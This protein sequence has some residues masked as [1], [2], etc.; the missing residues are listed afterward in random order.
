MRT[1]PEIVRAVRALSRLQVAPP[2]EARETA[3]GTHV[4]LIRLNDPEAV[5]P[6]Y[7]FPAILTSRAPYR[8]GGA[9]FPYEYE[10]VRT[11]VI[12][13][14]YSNLGMGGHNY[15]HAMALTESEIP[16]GTVPGYLA[17]PPW[18]SGPGNPNPAICING[19]DPPLGVPVHLF[20]SDPSAV[21]RGEGTIWLF[22]FVNALP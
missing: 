12:G 5:R 16:P 15:W 6:Y 10:W 17:G 7:P 13:T 9:A 11:A 4:R 21:E 1:V 19:R 3:D 18:R 8:H 22:D 2:L 20:P 14:P